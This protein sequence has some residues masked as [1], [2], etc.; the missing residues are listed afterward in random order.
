MSGL[1]FYMIVGAISESK[2]PV[3]TKAREM[4]DTFTKDDDVSE[5]AIG[6]H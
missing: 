3:Q 5:E 6:S 4:I 2:A 1:L